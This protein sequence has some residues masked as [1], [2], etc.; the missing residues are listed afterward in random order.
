MIINKA[1]SFF[2]KLKFIK[3][4]GRRK[5]SIKFGENIEKKKIEKHI[6]SNKN[7][8]SHISETKMLSVINEKF[9]VFQLGRGDDN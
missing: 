9:K 1:R 8:I 4:F 2:R 5:L 3:V 7:M 6:E